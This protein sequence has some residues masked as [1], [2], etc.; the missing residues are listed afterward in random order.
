MSD[1]LLLDVQW[2]TTSVQ[3]A[4]VA[5][6]TWT[7]SLTLPLD[8][9]EP[10]FVS[11]H[12]HFGS[13]T[14]ATYQTSFRTSDQAAETYTITA[15]EFDSERWDNDDDG[16]S[17][18]AELVN[19]TDPDFVEIE[20][21]PDPV[22]EL[23]S[24]EYSGYDLELFWTRAVDADGAV[25]GY[26]IYRNDEQLTSMLDSLSFYD[27]S[28]LPE[29]EYTYDVYSVD[30]EGFR[31]RAATLVLTTP[32]DVPVSGVDANTATL[33]G[34]GNSSWYISDGLSTTAGSWNSGSCSYGAGAGSGVGVTDASLPDNYDA[35]DFASLMWINGEQV[36][37]WLR[38][39]DG[40]TSNFSTVPM[41]NLTVATEY[42]A[43]STQP[44]LRN[45]TAFTNDTPDDIF[46]V[47]NVATNFGADGGNQIMQS[48]SGD[49]VF[50][51][52]DRW[53]ITDDYS[54]D[55]GD[56]TNTTV[57]FGPDSPVS[58][59]VFTGDSVF[60]CWGT[61]GLTARIDVVIPAGETRALMLFH[62]LS[63][64]FA[65]AQRLATIFD[66]TPTLDSELAEGLTE[67]QLSEAVNWNY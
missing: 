28:V 51:A 25:I 20:G 27:G 54:T 55:Y 35:F 10:L 46:I 63:Q 45:Y 36:G 50:G 15:S 38:S 56:P 31:S 59:S 37:G 47:V 53:V 24:I 64:T 42:H 12:D 17:N 61:Q 18:L 21:A 22:G 65:D 8:S 14:L 52:D 49:L 60:N 34:G 5:G 1:E 48:S 4:W 67:T 43:I 19:G 44:I 7:A 2:G 33:N 6:E 11:F 16:V 26:D 30:N 32:V 23:I 13:T 39:A 29:T 66:V 3:A 40:S 57:F 62:G 58:N 9:E 41:S